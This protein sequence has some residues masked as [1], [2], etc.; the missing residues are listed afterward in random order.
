MSLTQ[1]KEEY[2]FALEND[3]VDVVKKHH[4]HNFIKLNKL[5]QYSLTQNLKDT[6]MFFLSVSSDLEESEIRTL[7]ELAI[8]ENDTFYLKKLIE[9]FTKFDLNKTKS[10]Y[11]SIY[12]FSLI[13]L[14]I[15]KKRL[16]ILKIFKEHHV[17]FN[18]SDPNRHITPLHLAVLTKNKE[19][20]EFVLDSI[21]DPDINKNQLDYNWNTPLHYAGMLNHLD[22][23][24]CL[25]ESG[26]NINI[27]NKENKTVLDIVTDLE[28]IQYLEKHNAVRT[29]FESSYMI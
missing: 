29:K 9:T 17:D 6:F 18:I 16:D 28:S 25:V 11:Q 10:G 23:I 4:H 8:E 15:C 27:K 12:E 7:F 5:I 2:F 1:I 20:I 14:A 19:V 24:K 3:D 26:T 22:S 13:N 21:S